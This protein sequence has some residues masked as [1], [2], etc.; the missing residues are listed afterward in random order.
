MAINAINTFSSNIPRWIR[1]AANSINQLIRYN[2]GVRSATNVTANYTLSDNDTFL[3]VDAG[4]YTIT[5]AGEKDPGRRIIIKNGFASGTTTVSGTI[6][7]AASATVP[8]SYGVL[9]LISDGVQWWK[10]DGGAAGTYLPLAGG[11][12]TGPLIQDDLTDSTSTTTGSIQTDGGLG[13]AKYLYVGGWIVVKPTTGDA[14]V[15]L[16]KFTTGDNA[17]ILYKSA[18]SNTWTTGTDTND[19]YRIYTAGVAANVLTIDYT[20]GISTFSRGVDITDS[21]QST[22]TTTGSITTL[23]GIG[24]AK[25]VWV[26]GAVNSSS[27]GFVASNS[28]TYGLNVDS[29]NF[30][31]GSNATDTYI[32]TFNSN[33]L[34]LNNQ[35]NN[36]HIGTDLLLTGDLTVDDTTDSTG[37]YLTGS[38]QTDGGLGVAKTV[39]IGGTL[40]VTGTADGEIAR[41][42]QNSGGTNNMGWFYTVDDA[43]KTLTVKHSGAATP[44]EVFWEFGGGL[45]FMTATKTGLTMTF[46]GALIVDDTTDS[47]STTTG[48]IQT[49]GGI[50]VAKDVWVGSDIYMGTNNSSTIYFK[51]AA[52]ANAIAFRLSSADAMLYGRT[53]IESHT[54]YTQDTIRGSI[55]SD[56]RLNWLESITTDDTT[57]S[58]STITG[59]IQTDGGIGIAKAVVVGTT[60]DA[61]GNITSGTLSG[62]SRA[63]SANTSSDVI[64][65]FETSSAL[66]LMDIDSY[67]ATPTNIGIRLGISGTSKGSMYYNNSADELR[68]ATA[69]G[70]PASLAIDMTTDDA[71]FSSLVNLDTGAT[72]ARPTTKITG[73]MWFDTTLGTP[74]WYDGTNWIDAAG[75]TV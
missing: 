16:D 43:A 70:S 73:S 10:D 11:T 28:S 36:V 62:T 46:A 44:D 75:T 15:V 45:T 61:A 53:N 2:N 31:V 12:L 49:D 27:Q 29:N 67:H 57:D 37:G 63:I 51:D 32:Q 20:T 74:I 68:F 59:S 55:E 52:A 24:V 4:G 39:T 47:T 58:T 41:I 7:G 30:A 13:V 1:S 17:E 23:G 65:S 14:R 19:D 50:G 6:D 26:G 9:F 25:N 66:A 21:T 48:S 60:I 40:Q 5:L 56:G 3:L 64:S 18:G 35:G 22:S 69:A 34:H 33:T 42:R 54:F 38:I 72:G 71:T 8:T